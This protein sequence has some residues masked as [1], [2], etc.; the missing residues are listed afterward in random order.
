[1]SSFSESLK[2]YVGMQSEADVACDV[3]ERGGVRRYA[4]A[5]MNVH[6]RK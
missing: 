5:I 6:R 2:Q 3:V 1:M 4:Q